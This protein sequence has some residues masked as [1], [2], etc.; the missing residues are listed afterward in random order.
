[1]E[2]RCSRGGLDLSKPAKRRNPKK[3]TQNQGTKLRAW[4][5][6]DIRGTAH[7]RDK[8]LE[9][10]GRR[11]QLLKFLTVYYFP[12]ILP[13]WPVFKAESC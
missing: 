9:G 6:G 2:D 5:D 13:G 12:D 11:Y 7:C 4:L 3:T 8:N 10:N 1:V